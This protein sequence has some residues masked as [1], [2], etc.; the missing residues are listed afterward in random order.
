MRWDWPVPS[1]WRERSWPS[2]RRASERR[3][4][5]S[6]RRPIASSA[7][8][9]NRALAA[10]FRVIVPSQRGFAGTDAPADAQTYSVKNL[11]ADVSGLLDALGIDRAVWFGHDWGSMPA[12]YSGVQRIDHFCM[13]PER[14]NSYD[15]RREEPL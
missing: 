9:P 3:I 15:R 12:W 1:A 5:S 10:G 6:I 2:S 8:Y 7:G 13:D 14:H 4:R 11:V